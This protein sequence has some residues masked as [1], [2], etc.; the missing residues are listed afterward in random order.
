MPG[1][2]GSKYGIIQDEIPL[3]SSKNCRE[4]SSIKIER[5]QTELRD[6]RSLLPQLFHKLQSRQVDAK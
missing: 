6:L 1:S 4:A 2:A 3:K 5:E